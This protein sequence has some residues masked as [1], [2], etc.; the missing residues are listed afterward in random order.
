[1]GVEKYET[2]AIFMRWDDLVTHHTTPNKQQNSSLCRAWL[3]FSL[4]AGPVPGQVY[5]GFVFYCSPLL[6][7]GKSDVGQV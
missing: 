6:V 3:G 1:M 2:H 4:A 7:D 5:L